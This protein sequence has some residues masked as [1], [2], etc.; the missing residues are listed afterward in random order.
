M[1]LKIFFDKVEEQLYENLSAGSSAFQNISVHKDTFPEWRSCDIVLIGLTE[2]RGNSANKGVLTAANEIRKS[3]Y[4][5]KKGIKNIK[6]ADFGNLRNGET[7]E[8]TYERLKEVCGTLIENNIFIMLIGGSHDLDLGQYQAYEKFD[9]MITVVAVDAIADLHNEKGYGKS[10]SH[11][12][13]I[14]THE[15]NYLFHLCHLGH[16]AFLNDNQAFEALE[17][18]HFEM[19][20]LGSVKDNINETEPLIRQGDMF[21]FDIG[22]IKKND[23]PGNNLSNVY[24][25]AAEEACQICWYAG[26]N[27][28]LT[29]AGFYEYNPEK[30]NDG[31]TAF[32]I[33]T[34]MWYVIEGITN[35]VGDSDFEESRFM[36]YMISTGKA[37]DQILVFYKSKFSEKWWMEIPQ[38]GN[39][40]NSKNRM[41]PCSYSDYEK[42]LNGELPDR[43]LLM[44]GKLF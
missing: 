29:S 28:K 43:W 1:E 31:Q 20:R 2:N 27:D 12:H 25:L 39:K 9:K 11:L 5:L 4:Q 26:L 37:A 32:V 34:M 35:R 21:S 23:A 8:D 7:L 19:V 44:H 13:D 17:K 38:S 22:A 41:I 40:A 24:G 33:S 14:I 6:I 30:D 42:A 16:Q 3:F 15:P 10:S 36:R 18:L